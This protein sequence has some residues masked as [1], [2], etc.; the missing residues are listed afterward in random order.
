CK[1]DEVF[2]DAFVQQRATECTSGVVAR[3]KVLFAP[4]KDKSLEFEEVTWLPALRR[5]NDVHK[6]EQLG[7]DNYA[8]EMY[9]REL[10]LT[11]DEGHQLTG[12]NKERMKQVLRKH[13]KY[14]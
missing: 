3:R 9:Q 13:D 6:Y 10:A 8:N 2:T 7:I 1:V 14:K 11:K 5:F 4:R 12:F